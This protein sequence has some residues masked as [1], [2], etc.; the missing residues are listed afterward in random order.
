MDGED[1]CN[2]VFFK[3]SCIFCIPEVTYIKAREN[4]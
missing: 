2:T 1:V 4:L 3:L